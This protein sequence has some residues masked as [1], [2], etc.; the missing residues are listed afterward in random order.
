MQQNY[1]NKVFDR[2]ISHEG[3]YVNNPADPGG[4]TKFGISKRSYPNVDIANLSLEQAREIYRLDFWEEI[5][6]DNLSFPL[7]YQLFDFAVNSGISTAIRYLQRSLGVADDG[8]W[9]PHSR[10]AMDEFIHLRGQN[11]LLMYL[12]A[13][14]QLFQ[15]RL[16]AWKDFGRGWAVRNALNLKIGADDSVT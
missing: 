10:T 2:V 14:R 6:G 9:G 3:G 15:T 13:E 12:I 5:D 1:F 4:E 7:A 16:K 11:D 8:H